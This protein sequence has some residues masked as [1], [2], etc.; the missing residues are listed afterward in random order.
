MNIYYTSALDYRLHFPVKSSPPITL[1]ILAR[2]GPSLRHC[3][4]YRVAVSF[5]KIEDE[6]S[7]QPS[8]VHD[9]QARSFPYNDFSEF[10]RPDQTS[11][12]LVTR[13]LASDCKS[14]RIAGDVEG[15]QNSRLYKSNETANA[16]W[17]TKILKYPM[18]NLMT[19]VHPNIPTEDP[20]I[21]DTS[22]GASCSATEDL[23][24]LQ[25]SER[26]PMNNIQT[27]WA[28]FTLD[29][30]TYGKYC[31]R[32]ITNDTTRQVRTWK[33]QLK[34]VIHNNNDAPGGQDIGRFPAREKNH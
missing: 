9:R 16:V 10:H 21:Y 24:T 4:R 26:D 19:M 31:S 23:E 33:A 17:S 22:A 13:F 5:Q 28:K 32:F 7:A 30:T 20:K 2:N 18:K 14:N 25:L 11:F 29:V 8:G 6:L 12:K 34:I 15:T 3:I 1:F 27:L